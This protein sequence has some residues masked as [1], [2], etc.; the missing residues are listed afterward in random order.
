M[1]CGSPLG[2]RSKSVL[3]EKEW[4]KPLVCND[5]VTITKEIELKD[6][7]ANLGA[8]MLREGRR[9]DRRRRR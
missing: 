8:Q 9:K 1:R 2:P 6:P 3:I 5:G 7:E 4:G